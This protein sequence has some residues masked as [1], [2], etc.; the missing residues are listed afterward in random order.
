MIQ[1]IIFQGCGFNYS[2]S[3]PWVNW[4]WS[5]YPSCTHT[6]T[7]TTHQTNLLELAYECVML[8]ALPRTTPVCVCVC[9]WFLWC[10]SE[11]WNIDNWFIALSC[12]CQQRFHINLTHTYVH[13]YTHTPSSAVWATGPQKW[14]GQVLWNPQKFKATQ[15][16]N[17]I[18]DMAAFCHV[19][20]TT[21]TT[22]LLQ[23]HMA[24]QQHRAQVVVWKNG[25]VCSSPLH[26]VQKGTPAKWLSG[27]H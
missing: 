5:N 3:G 26:S 4:R 1:F 12:T 20:T 14:S 8:V 6:H 11:R 17:A 9:L 10:A 22:T 13:T 18:L 27:A 25:L 21:T 24:W 7:H 23:H 16:I 15:I 19:N 2:L